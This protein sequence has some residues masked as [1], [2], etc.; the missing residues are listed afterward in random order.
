MELYTDIPI[1]E[2]NFLAFV[3]SSGVDFVDPMEDLHAIN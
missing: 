2:V 3:Y 1:S